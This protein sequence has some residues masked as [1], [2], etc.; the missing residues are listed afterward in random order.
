MAS[1]NEVIVLTTEQL[2]DMRF[3]IEKFEEL[4]EHYVVA[5]KNADIEI[6]GEKTVHVRFVE[7]KENESYE[8][9]VEL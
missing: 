9:V 8:W 7:D 2:A 5:V 3:A 4:Y 6:T 1:T